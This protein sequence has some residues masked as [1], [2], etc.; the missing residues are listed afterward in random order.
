MRRRLTTALGA[1]ALG[2]L[3]GPGWAADPVAAPAPAGAGC[4]SCL[5]PN[6]AP[7]LVGGDYREDGEGSGGH[8]Q[9]GVGF[10]YLK[11][12]PHNDP[13][14]FTSER[15]FPPGGI[16]VENEHRTQTDFHHDYEL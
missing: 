16:F 9:A 10:Y 11:A 1:L 6:A 8:V 2:W 7:A 15:N 4:Q 14:F 5:V 13:A 12:F 3:A